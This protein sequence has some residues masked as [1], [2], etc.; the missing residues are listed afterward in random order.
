MKVDINDVKKFV[1]DELNTSTKYL[2]I[3]SVSAQERGIKETVKYLI[4][5]FKDLGADQVITF[6]QYKNPAI[7]ASFTGNSPKTVLFYN[8]YDVQPPDPL[9]EW[10]S[11]P[12][13]PTIRDG[14][15]YARGICDDKGELMSRL[16]VVRYFKEHG[17][18]PCNLK[19]FIEGEEEI[20]SPNIE[21]YASDAAKY[22]TCDAVIWE[23]GG[24]NEAEKF[25]I[26]AGTKGIASFEAKVTTAESD[27]HSSLAPY[28]DNAA[29]RLVQ[30]LSSLYGANRNI[31]VDHFY[32]NVQALSPYAAEQVKQQEASFDAATVINAFG[33]TQGKLPVNNPFSAVMTEPTITINGLSAGYEGPGVKTVIP[34]QATAKLDCR[35]VP[36]Q[37]PETIVG[38]LQDQLVKNGFPDIKLHF[39]LG[40][41]AYRTDLEDPF[42]QLSSRI[43]AEI[44]GPDKVALIPNQPGGGPMLPFFKITQAPLMGIGVHY[45][46]S[47][48]HAPNENIRISDYAQASGYLARLLE[49]FGQQA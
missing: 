40:E 47:T 21:K 11:D 49:E 2:E 3:P 42:I 32:D 24:K 16:A 38:Y 23:G 25:Q 1:T 36:G 31:K 5:W 6:D 22:L 4:D 20:G 35:L 18:L 17:G 33:V 26:I 39:L 46:A 37:D 29:W 12:F 13:K 34:R 45:A 44:Y 7:F 30:G 43:A 10:E 14:K 28:L 48:P 8:H 27:A 9:D 19:F 41:D 15:L